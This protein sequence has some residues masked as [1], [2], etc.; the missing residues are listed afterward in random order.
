MSAANK[1]LHRDMQELCDMRNWLSFP[2]P[3]ILSIMFPA[4]TGSLPQMRGILNDTD[5]GKIEMDLS[6]LAPENDGNLAEKLAVIKQK[7]QQLQNETSTTVSASLIALQTQLEIIKPKLEELCNKQQATASTTA[8]QA[9]TASL[10]PQ[11]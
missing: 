6:E 9:E 11:L 5:F 8:A 4:I 7:L 2:L 1:L 3:A 10:L